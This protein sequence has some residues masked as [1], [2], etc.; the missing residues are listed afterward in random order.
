MYS[1]INF[2]QEYMYKKITLDLHKKMK[3]YCTI[4]VTMI[5]NIIST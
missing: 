1:C 4:H 2:M 3:P 5:H